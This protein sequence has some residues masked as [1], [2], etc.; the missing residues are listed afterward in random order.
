MYEDKTVTILLVIV[1]WKKLIY[2]L[3]FFPIL[4][5]VKLNQYFLARCCLVGGSNSLL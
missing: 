3:D 1:I 4:S 5:K 2:W